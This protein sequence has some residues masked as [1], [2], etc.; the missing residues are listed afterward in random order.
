MRPNRIFLAAAAVAIIGFA[1]AIASAP[2]PSLAEGFGTHLIS[3]ADYSTCAVVSGGGVQCWGENEDGQLGDGT[4]TDRST[5]VDVCATGATAP[6]KASD[7]TVLTG[8]VGV[9]A[10]YEHTCAVTSAGTAK[11]W[12]DNE[13]GQLGAGT[14]TDSTTP[15]D[16][17]ATGATPPCTPGNNNILTGVAVAQ[18]GG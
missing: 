9:A 18:A 7:D 2:G 3:T 8:V 10:G 11:C 13:F 4:T 5:P 16:V 15:V 6:C 17:C 14:L 1:M 12:G